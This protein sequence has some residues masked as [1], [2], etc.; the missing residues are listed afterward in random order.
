M[1]GQG[2]AAFFAEATVDFG[3]RPE[4]LWLPTCPCQMGLI[5]ADKRTEKIAKLFLAHAAMA[6]RWSSDLARMK[7]HCAALAA[8]GKS[9]FLHD[10]PLLTSG[11]HRS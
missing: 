11:L 3:R 1:I 10:A 2:R 6:D 7:P 5:G 4:Q 8:T 9:A